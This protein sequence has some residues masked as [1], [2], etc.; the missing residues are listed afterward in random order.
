VTRVGLEVRR[1]P[2]PNPTHSNPT[3]LPTSSPFQMFPAAFMQATGFHGQPFSLI[4]SPVPATVSQVF[5]FH[6]RSHSGWLSLPDD[7]LTHSKRDTLDITP[8]TAVLT[9]PLG[10][11][12]F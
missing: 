4:S 7:P 9:P 8:A 2:H 10:A 6:A 11:K 5:E 1:S 3:T 12:H